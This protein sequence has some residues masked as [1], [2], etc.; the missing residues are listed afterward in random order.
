MTRSWL[1]TARSWLAGGV[2]VGAARG[3]A[4]V[5]ARM[6]RASSRIVRENARTA[7]AR[8]EKRSFSAFHLKAQGT[9]AFRA[10]TVVVYD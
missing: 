10:H 3:S 7:R 9:R 4:A 5:N 2:G 1:W 6:I 8:A